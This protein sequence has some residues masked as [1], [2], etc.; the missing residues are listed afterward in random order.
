LRIVDNNDDFV[1]LFTYTASTQNLRGFIDIDLT[2]GTAVAVLSSAGSNT[3]N[4]ATVVA[5]DTPVTTATTSV[6]FSLTAGNFDGGSVLIYGI[7]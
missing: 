3:M 2:N 1:S 6:G 5:G 4:A 7:P